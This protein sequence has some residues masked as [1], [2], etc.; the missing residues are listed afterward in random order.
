MQDFGK[1]PLLLGRV[2][3]DTGTIGLLGS[4][5]AFISFAINPLVG[6]GVVLVVANDVASARAA[7]HALTGADDT[8][9]GH[10]MNLAAG[11]KF[12]KVQGEN[13]PEV[14]AQSSGSDSP[15]TAEDDTW[16]GSPQATWSPPAP[17]LSLLPIAAYKGAVPA[18]D[19]DVMQLH[20]SGV[21]Q[22]AT[23]AVFG[24]V[25]TGEFNN[26]EHL[27]WAVFGVTKGGGDWYPVAAQFC[28]RCRD[29]F[30]KGGTVSPQ[31]DSRVTW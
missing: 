2:T 22:L 13:T 15:V 21:R 10:T 31:R 17:D 14:Q 26:I 12:K 30:V 18:G 9:A 5:I 20:D 19:I 16:D 3:D 11:E 24:L 23:D 1:A 4:A 27:V 6:L 7:R 29:H 8:G 28:N 25:T